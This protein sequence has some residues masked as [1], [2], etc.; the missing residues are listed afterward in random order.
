MLLF[1]SLQIS[2]THP[3][4]RKVL[5]L[6]LL[7]IIIVFVLVKLFQIIETIW[8]ELISHK[9]LFRHFYVFKRK[10]TN[11]QKFILRN[12]FYF[13]KKLSR[14]EQ[15]FFEHRVAHFIKRN[16][17]IGKSD[18]KIDDVHKVLIS[19]TAVMLTFGYRNYKLKWVERF[20]IYPDVYYSNMNKTYHKGEFNPSFKA[21][22]MSWKNFLHGY[23]IEDDNF[24]LGIHEVVHALHFEYLDPKNNSTNA[25]IFMYHYDKLREFLD[26]DD[27]YKT[28]LV[29]SKYLRDYAYTNK[30]E[31]IAVLI[32]SF[33][34]T[35]SELKS[36]FPEMY[37]YVKKML[38]FNFAG[39]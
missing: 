33:I 38:N 15:D 25:V 21:I 19:A 24:N 28:R 20:L 30:F 8:V 18:L 4:F 32:E 10:L 7:S 17:F 31:F 14:K 6:I 22:I 9:P 23:K 34:E 12:Q 29:A 11:S 37:R 1:L 2:D 35:P 26:A 36:Q 39:Y 16:E 3:I 13:Y 27:D 5:G